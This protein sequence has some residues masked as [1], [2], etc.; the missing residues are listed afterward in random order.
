M[1]K[2]NVET[3]KIKVSERALLA[4]LRRALAKEG[5]ILKTTRPRDYSTLGDYYIVND[6][7]CVT[8]AGVD[9]ESLAREMKLLKPYEE[10]EA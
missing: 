4:R 9:L 6:R 8:A 2:T 3:I 10:V 5:E 7:N 1:K